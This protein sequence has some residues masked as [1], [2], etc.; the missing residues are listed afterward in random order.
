MWLPVG[1]P[2][3]S[4][5]HWRLLV[6]GWKLFASGGVGGLKRGWL[7]E[8][9]MSERHPAQPHF[10]LRS[11]GAGLENQGC[12]IGSALIKAGLEACD[13][14]CMP[15]YLE[16][17]NVRNNALY[18]RHGFEVIGEAKLPENGPTIWFMH[19]E[20]RE[21]SLGVGCQTTA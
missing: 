20:A 19:R 18:Q 3:K 13:Q 2:L 4:P 11:I 21:K 12:G 10:Y 1:A 9:L 17:S 6:A 15:A 7:V 16:S 5:F 14:Q 8:K